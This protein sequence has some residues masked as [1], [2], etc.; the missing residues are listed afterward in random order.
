M[1]LLLAGLLLL[2]TPP[3]WQW[4]AAERVVALGDV[5]GDLRA[6]RTALRLG[7]LTDA[8]GR[9]T[10]GQT[11][12]V[13]TGDVLDRGDGEREIF[14]LLFRLQGEAQA[15]GGRV[16]LLNGNHELMNAAGDLRYV[17]PGGFAAFTDTWLPGDGLGPVPIWARG[18]RAAFMPGGPWAK[19]LAELPVVATVGDTAF[20]HGGLLADHVGQVPAMHRAVYAWLNGAGPLPRALFVEDAPVWTRRWSSGPL[21]A[22]DCAELSRVLSGFGVNRLVVGHTVQP[23]ITQACDGAVWRV[24]VGMAAHYGGQPAVL[25]IKGDA[26]RAV[27][28]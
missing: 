11:V 24:D 19:R 28:R 17:T 12:L 2:A 3:A 6:T 14:E 8:D 21:T 5:H 20:V 22:G 23:T 25:E 15:A 16:V 27:T 4:P 9:W 18:R 26:V 13:Q 1:T 10:G 7:G